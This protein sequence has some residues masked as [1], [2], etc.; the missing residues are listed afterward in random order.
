[1]KPAARHRVV[2]IG[3][4]HPR[5]LARRPGALDRAHS[6]SPHPGSTPSAERLRRTERHLL[7]IGTTL[8]RLPPSARRQDGVDLLEI[9]VAG[10]PARRPGRAAASG[11]R[12]LSRCGP[13]YP[14]SSSAWQQARSMRRSGIA[15]FHAAAAAV[16]RNEARPGL[17]LRPAGLLATLRNQAYFS[18]ASRPGPLSSPLFPSAPSLTVVVLLSISVRPCPAGSA[19]AALCCRSAAAR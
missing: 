1:M 11:P 5:R 19:A 17:R 15:P 14:G 7:S 10:I 9:E 12:N 2:R 18:I 4:R 3:C 6:A 13:V 8:V 16:R